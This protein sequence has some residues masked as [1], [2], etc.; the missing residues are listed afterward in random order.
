MAHLDTIDNLRQG[1]G[2]RGYAQRD[3]LVEYK[4]EAYRMFEQLMFNLDDE[5]VHRIY[6]VQ[7]QQNP[8]P[9]NPPHGAPGHV[10]DTQTHTHADGSVHSGPAHPD[11][12]A[13]VPVETVVPKPQKKKMI[14]NTPESEISE[15]AK[16]PV[17]ASAKLSRND[18]CWCGSGK[19]WKKCHYPNLPA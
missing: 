10:H 9:T 2:L 17:Q 19:K 7:V 16:A 15:T 5:I 12:A 13:A 8:P 1:I 14:T 4:N 11:Q 6:K 18:P 3:P